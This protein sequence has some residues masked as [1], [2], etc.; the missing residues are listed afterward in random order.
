MVVT[1]ES[2]HRRSN[3]IYVRMPATIVV[4]SQ[5]TRVPYEATT[6]D[7]SALGARVRLNVALIPGERVEFVLAGKPQGPF[8]SEVVWA[9][10]ACSEQGRDVGL[11]FLRPLAA[12]SD[13]STVLKSPRGQF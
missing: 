7:F 10:Q 8:L 13:D 12:A 5:G 9:A 3:R 1:A 2:A 4:D 11:E 6:I